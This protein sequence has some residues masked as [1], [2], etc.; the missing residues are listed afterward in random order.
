MVDRREERITRYIS[1]YSAQGI[2]RTGTETDQDSATWMADIIAELGCE[3]SFNEFT[4]PRVIIET[5]ELQFDGQVI[6]GVPLFDCTYTGAEGVSGKLGALDS[7]S[8]IGVVMIPPNSG[9]AEV[10]KLLESRRQGHHLA[11][12]AV[13]HSNMPGDGVATLNAE[14]FM[15]PFGPPVLQIANNQWERLLTA[16]Q[17]RNRAKVTVHCRRQES[18]ARNVGCIVR[19]KRPELAPLVV[20]TPRSGW[21][22]C[23]SERGGGIAAFFEIMRA[24]KQSASD[25]DVIFTANSGHELDHLGLDLYLHSQQHLIKDAVA[26]I[27][28]GA[29]FATNLEP[30]VILQ[31]S[32]EKIR[33]AALEQTALSGAT[34]SMEWPIGRRAI[35]EARNIFDGG[36]RFVSI[37][38]GNGWFHHPADVWPDAVD[39]EATSVWVDAFTRIA[40][41]LASLEAA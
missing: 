28:L 10:K 27:H 6:Q 7:K 34:P 40:L 14:D 18:Q 30:R 25:R 20:M 16:S 12:V 29:N 4:F 37:L 23:A 19:G 3:P 22:R 39:L 9:S 36:G 33:L 5:A 31:F 15:H 2:H 38:G 41:M 17:N 11:I 13:T 32:D 8:E 1:E 21:W 24:V 35:G 26:W